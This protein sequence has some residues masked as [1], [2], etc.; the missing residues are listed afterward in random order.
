MNCYLT[1]INVIRQILSPGSRFL[2]A[3]LMFSDVPHELAA[4][5]FRV[6]FNG[7]NY[8]IK[9]TVS[10]MWT[11]RKCFGKRITKM[12]VYK[13]GEVNIIL[14]LAKLW[15]LPCLLLSESSVVFS[16]ESSGRCFWLTTQFHLVWSAEWAS[17]YLLLSVFCSSLTV[18]TGLWPPSV[19]VSTRFYP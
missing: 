4:Y 3:C 7:R 15:G 19:L 2:V 14:Q 17:L 13:P 8:R 11:N 10:E 9:L 16:L 1:G 5:I 6:V 18:H 12:N